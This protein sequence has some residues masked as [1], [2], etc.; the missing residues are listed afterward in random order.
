MHPFLQR[1]R[2]Q[3]TIV[4]VNQ[5]GFQYK[6]KSNALIN[7]NSIELKFFPKFINFV[8][9]FLPI[10]RLLAKPQTSLTFKL[11][12]NLK[13]YLM[14]IFQHGRYQELNRRSSFCE[15][16]RIRSC[17]ACCS[18]PVC[19]SPSPIYPSGFQPEGSAAQ[20][21]FRFPARGQCCTPTGV[22]LIHG[23]LI[24]WFNDGQPWGELRGYILHDIAA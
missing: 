11:N 5:T 22:R 10:F 14:N 13:Q 19:S 17:E 8:R 1:Q 24:T 4:V 3:Y 2:L 9:K 21:P 6:L 12:K 15:Q 23:S 18:M 7:S 16:V 20:L